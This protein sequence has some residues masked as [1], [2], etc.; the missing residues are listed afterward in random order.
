ML[1]L[2]LA[3]LVM[4]A[5]SPTPEP[6]SRMLW[7]WEV[8]TDLRFLNP[9][10]AGV[11]WL[12]MTVYLDGTRTA[13]EPRSATLEV[14]P[15]VYQMA[16]VRLEKAYDSAPPKWTAEQRRS[17][18]AA[19]V[20]LVRITH[21]RAV[22]IDFDAPESAHAF[23]RALMADLRR[24]LDSGVFLSMTAL[25][26][27]CAGPKNWIDDFPVDEIVPMNFDAGYSWP[28]T[29]TPPAEFSDPACRKSIGVMYPT[30]ASTIP[31]SVRHG[32]RVYFFHNGWTSGDV[33]G[34][35]RMV[36]R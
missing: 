24:R 6:P 23:Y 11:A 35:F 5:G 21:S 31:P 10:D 28:R 26:S 4:A 27:W 25:V 22:Q 32:E 15:G 16:V 18:V 1:P 2:Q 33:R 36:S 9:S 17:A 19:I 29:S 30:R 7:A 12:A 20:D 13:P 34:A 14:P 3:L 8:D